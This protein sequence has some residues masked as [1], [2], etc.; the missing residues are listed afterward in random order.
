MVLNPHHFRDTESPTLSW[1]EKMA[2]ARQD[3]WGQ[4]YDPY[5]SPITFEAQSACEHKAPLLQSQPVFSRE[6]PALP[7]SFVALSPLYNEIR[8]NAPCLVRSARS[9]TSALEVSTSSEIEDLKRRLQHI[10]IRRA[11]QREHTRLIQRDLIEMEMLSALS[12]P[13]NVLEQP[14]VLNTIRVEETPTSVF[15]S[16]GNSSHGTRSGLNPKRLLCSTYKARDVTPSPTHERLQ[17]SKENRRDSHSINVHRLAFLDPDRLLDPIF[18]VSRADEDVNMIQ[19]ERKNTSGCQGHTSGFDP[20]SSWPSID[21]LDTLSPTGWTFTAVGE[22]QTNCL[23]DVVPT[24]TCVPQQLPAWYHRPDSI[25]TDVSHQAHVMNVVFYQRGNS[26]VDGR[27][28]IP[29]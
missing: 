14:E 12:G 6:T 1:P 9:T 28:D 16:S 18:C 2:T 13:N 29:Y 25:A 15:E 10:K 17:G 19:R 11:R 23:R 21:G 22:H 4:R 20:Y 24:K 27:P 3:P 26:T 7:E 5:S 8:H